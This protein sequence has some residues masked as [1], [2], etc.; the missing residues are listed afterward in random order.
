MTMMGEYGTTDC[1]ATIIREN[2]RR[3]MRAMNND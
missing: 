2:E 3:E 1:A